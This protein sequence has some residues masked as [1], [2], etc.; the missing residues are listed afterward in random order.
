MQSHARTLPEGVLLHTHDLNTSVHSKR[1]TLP[2]EQGFRDRQSFF[3]FYGF[4]GGFLGLLVCA[5]SRK[6]C[7]VA[8]NLRR[9]LSHIFCCA[10]GGGFWSHT[11]LKSCMHVCARKILVSV[12]SLSFSLSWNQNDRWI[13]SECVIMSIC[14]DTLSHLS[15]SFSVYVCVCVWCMYKYIHMEITSTEIESETEIDSL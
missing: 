8:Q 2:L 10:F 13:V 9:V 5:E 15:R 3:V 12:S 6:R 7:T 4:K 14:E 11:F 1:H